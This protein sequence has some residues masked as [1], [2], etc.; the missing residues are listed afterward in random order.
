MQYHSMTLGIQNRRS[1]INC[2]SIQWIESA[3]AF[4]L[5]FCLISIPSSGNH[6]WQKLSTCLLE[7]VSEP[8][9]RCIIATWLCVNLRIKG[10]KPFNS[11]VINEWMNSRS[12]WKGWWFE[13]WGCNRQDNPKVN[14]SNGLWF[15]FLILLT[16]LSMLIGEQVNVTQSF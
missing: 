7:P 2:I 3:G 6:P 5:S 15:G 13:R 11:W 14:L 4:P 10:W 9:K 16:Y 8:Y 12:Q 1:W